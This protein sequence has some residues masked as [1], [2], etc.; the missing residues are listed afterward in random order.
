MV[1]YQIQI[2]HIGC[3]NCQAVAKLLKL[4]LYASWDW[5]VLLSSQQLL[6]SQ[7]ARNRLEL[8]CRFLGIQVYHRLNNCIFKIEG[9]HKKL[10]DFR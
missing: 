1:S 8:L 9:Y 7:Q 6:W 2:Q 5:N 10:V 4:H 3:R